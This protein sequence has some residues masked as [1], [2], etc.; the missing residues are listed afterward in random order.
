MNPTFG[1]PIESLPN[2]GPKSA[3]WLRAAGIETAERLR[4][5]RAAPAF[6]RV[7]ATGV[8]PSRNLLWALHGALGGKSWLDVTPAEKRRLERRLSLL[9]R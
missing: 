8:R 9:D 5:L 2:L 4:E 3:S 6:L 7:K 1:E